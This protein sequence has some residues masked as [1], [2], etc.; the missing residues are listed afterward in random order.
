MLNIAETQHLFAEK[1][2][3]FFLMSFVDLHGTPR[4]KLV[5]AECLEDVCAGAAGFAGFAVDGVGQGPHDPDLSCTPVADSTVFPLPWKPGMAWIA[6]NLTMDGGEWAHCPR[7]ILSRAMADAK[8]Q[9]FLFKVGVEPEFFLIDKKADGS[10][11]VA[12]AGDTL[13]KPCYGQLSLLRNADFLTTVITYANQLGY[14]VYQN[15]HEDANGQ[16]EINWR[17]SDALT[18]ADRVSFFKFM[19]KALAEERGLCATFMPKPFA[20]LTGNGSHMHL[21][22]WD[23]EGKDNL[24]LDKSDPLGLSSLALSFLAGILDH[25]KGL[26][27]LTAPSVNS[28]KRFGARSPRSGATWAPIYI[29]YGGN[30][31]TM[32]VRVPAPGRMEYRTAD[33]SSNP[34][35]A[36]AALLAAGLDG[37]K[38]GLRPADPRSGNLF[39]LS[40]REA[41]AQ[42]IEL[43]PANLGE[44]LDELEKDDVLCAALGESYAQTYLE[45]KREEWDEYAEMIAKDVSAWELKRYLGL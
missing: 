39:L 13:A 41:R 21:S 37:V 9:G 40:P 23:T 22:L 5:P 44:A 1:N 8:S 32:M 11:G 38:R 35:L 4:A 24:F 31:R 18:T 14:G 6:G 20:N 28:Y 17:Y 29:A 27:A 25:A 7:T 16:F 42:G 34:Y 36:S 19:V 33:G 12:D 30:N 15:D 10:I 43:L 3:Q 26:C 2:I 45:T